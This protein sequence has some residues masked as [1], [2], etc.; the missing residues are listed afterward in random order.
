MLVVLELHLRGELA[1][2]LRGGGDLADGFLLDAQA[3]DEAGDLR[4]A[5]LPTHDLAHHVQHFVVE[6][7]A[8]LDAA[9]DRFGDSDFHCTLPSMK[10]LSIACP[11]SVS[12]ASGWNCTPSTGSVRCRSPMT[13]PSSA[14]ALTSRQSGSV[15]RST[16]SE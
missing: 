15:S 3:D 6:H 2:D 8:V 1:H 16:A 9:L 10:F 4:L 13:S 14:C 7:L 12:R 5:E 11:C